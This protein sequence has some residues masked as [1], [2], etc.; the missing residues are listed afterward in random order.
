M[1]WCNYCHCYTVNGRCPKCNRMY[2]EPNKKYDFYGKEIKEPQQEQR[3][4]TGRVTTAAVPIND[5]A[6]SFAGGLFLAFVIN[7]IAIIIAVK[8]EKRRMRNGA[9][10]GTIIGG[11]FLLTI[12]GTIVSSWLEFGPE[13]YL[14]IYEA[15][16][17]TIATIREAIE[18]SRAS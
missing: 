9:I 5:G 1:A 7:F 13:W 11:V 10:V 17:E 12:L 16:K 6:G 8:I 15:L 2:E 14:Q 18:S 3:K 4:S